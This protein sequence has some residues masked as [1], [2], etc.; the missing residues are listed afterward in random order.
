MG[1]GEP[2]PQMLELGW[3]RWTA[4]WMPW[5]PCPCEKAACQCPS[6]L[7]EVI[8]FLCWLSHTGPQCLPYH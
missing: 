7:A 3:R 1:G 8:S 2:D 4:F 6:G 5:V